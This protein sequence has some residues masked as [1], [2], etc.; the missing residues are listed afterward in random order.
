VNIE[1]N[2]EAR[3]RDNVIAAINEAGINKDWAT[4]KTFGVMGKQDTAILAVDT[5]FFNSRFDLIEHIAF[6][7]KRR[8]STAD[9]SIE[10]EMSKESVEVVKHAINRLAEANRFDLI[11]KF[12]DTSN[13]EEVQEMLRYAEKV[14][15]DASI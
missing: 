11:G 5:L 2:P 8:I 1:K 3:K 12:A 10:S 13:M 14:I 9:S 4:L 7:R 15:R 6:Q